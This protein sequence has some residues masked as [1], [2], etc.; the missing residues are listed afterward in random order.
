[1]KVFKTPSNPLSSR[2]TGILLGMI[3]GGWSGMLLKLVPLMRD[4][5]RLLFC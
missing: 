3:F 2:R 5:L 1:M 4:Y